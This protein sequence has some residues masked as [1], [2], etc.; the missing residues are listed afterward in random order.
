MINPTGKEH[1][2]SYLYLLSEMAWAEFKIRDQGTFFGFLWTLLY[3]ALMLVVL[4]MLF[5]KWMG[6]F[7]DQ[8]A[9]YLLIGLL[10]W[11][12]FQKSTSYALT[13]LSR[14]HSLITNFKFP[15]EIIIFSSLAS[16]LYAFL[17][18]ICVLCVFLLFLGIYPKPAWLMLPP[19]IVVTLLLTAGVSLFLSLL[20]TEYQDL[21][22]IWDVCS[23]ALFYL[24]PIFYP[25]SI[26]SE[27]HQ[28]WLLF[29]PIT[30][31]LIAVRGCLIDG[32]LPN[33]ASL[34][35]VTL[36]SGA[37]F[38]AGIFLLRRY[39]YHVIDRIMEQ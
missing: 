18:E 5:V 1:A 33:A 10:F 13:S 36:A 17:L 21:E 4:Y 23:M 38:A 25:L 34:A 8:Y 19:L 24:T 35:A 11:N 16:I 15:R 32:R 12:F 39:E 27:R 2:H 30:Q 31:I 14:R 29:N 9:A 22:R 7:V 28:P 3:P 37:T 6:R 26:I 20:A